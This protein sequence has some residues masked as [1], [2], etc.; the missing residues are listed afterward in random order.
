MQTSSTSLTSHP[1]QFNLQMDADFGTSSRRSRA[2][3]AARHI[4]KS[5]GKNSRRV[6]IATCILMVLAW[7]LLAPYDVKSLITRQP[8]ITA[9]DVEDI[10]TLPSCNPSDDNNTT[11]I[12][13]IVHFVYLLSDPRSDFP[14]QFSHFLSMYGASHLWRPEKIYLHTNVRVDSDTVSRARSGKSGKWSKLIFNLP[15]FS[16]NTVPL[17]VYTKKGVRVEMM[18]HRS[19][20][21]RVKMVHDF[22]GIYMDLDVQPLRD[23]RVLRE[24]GFKAVGGRELGGN[25]NSGTFM[26]EKEGEA[27]RQWM[28]RMHNVFDQGWTTHSNEAWTY[29]AERLEDTCEVLILGRDAFAPGSWRPADVSKLFDTHPSDTPPLDEDIPGRSLP[30]EIDV[31]LEAKPAWASNLDCTFLLHAFSPKKPRHGVRN[32]GITPRYVLERRSNYARAVYPMV[33]AM[34]DEGL[35]GIDDTD[36]G[37]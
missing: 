20:F 1:P 12:P 24:S 26:S 11:S 7:W 13:N 9:C 22:G 35:V 15:N 25:L 32:N 2:W 5:F 37:T 28:D 31:E 36:L 8:S 3:K 14:F 6:T 17:P 29:V 30:T 4:M 34:H 16:L 19:D 23:I 21:V 27:I 18:E 33:K 10:K